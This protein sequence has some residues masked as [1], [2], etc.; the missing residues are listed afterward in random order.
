MDTVIDKAD[1][2]QQPQYR[3]VPLT[4]KQWSDVQT[5]FGK[6]GYQGDWHLR[7]MHQALDLWKVGYRCNAVYIPVICKTNSKMTCFVNPP[8][9]HPMYATTLCFERVR[10]C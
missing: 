7:A 8:C 2:L 1:L 10:I 4:I 5:A 9:D 6:A 3:K